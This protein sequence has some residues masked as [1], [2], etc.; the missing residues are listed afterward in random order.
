MSLSHGH[1]GSKIPAKINT[2]ILIGA[3]LLIHL[4]YEIPCHT[5]SKQEPKIA[6]LYCKVPS[7]LQICNIYQSRRRKKD[8]TPPSTLKNSILLHSCMNSALQFRLSASFLSLLIPSKQSRSGVI[9]C[10]TFWDSLDDAFTQRALESNLV[11]VCKC[12]FRIF[13][14]ACTFKTNF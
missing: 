2:Y 11:V 3:E 1:V 4:C 8:S 13:W 6:L 12:K 7:K 10:L 9:Y 5:V 14:G